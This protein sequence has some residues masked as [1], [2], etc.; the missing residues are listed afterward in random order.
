[1]VHQTLRYSL[2]K[3]LCKLLSEGELVVRCVSVDRSRCCVSKRRVAQ[4]PFMCT[5]KGAGYA[6]YE[7][8]ISGDRLP[9]ITYGFYFY[10]ISIGDRCLEY[11]WRVKA[12]HGGR[13]GV[14]GRGVNLGE[15]GQEACYSSWDGDLP[16]KSGLPTCIFRKGASQI[17]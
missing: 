7:A 15:E 5:I 16:N 2:R 9:E 3:C 12:R 4:N 13:R 11:A 17:G 1:M 14:W 8:M 10:F 6:F